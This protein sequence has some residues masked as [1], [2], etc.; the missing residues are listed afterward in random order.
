MATN[1]TATE[2][3][4]SGIKQQFTDTFGKSYPL[5]NNYDFS[6]C[7]V[8]REEVI[9]W[10]PDKE[11]DPEGHEF[12]DY[13]PVDDVSE[14]YGPI[15]GEPQRV[16]VLHN[17]DRGHVVNADKVD[18]LAEIVDESPESLMQSAHTLTDYPA[19]TPMFELS[20]GKALIAPILLVKHKLED[21]PDAVSV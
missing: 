7:V 5:A 13:T 10:S 9:M 1:Q 19:H 17:D 18:Q 16:Y 21:T 4:E 11:A 2:A 15:E 12:D 20:D 14:K 8:G 6:G 3:A